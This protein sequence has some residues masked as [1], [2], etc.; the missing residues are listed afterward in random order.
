MILERAWCMPRHKTFEI[1]PVKKL[2]D[3]ELNSDFV[4]PF[5]YPYQRDALEYLKSFDDE[6][7]QNLAFDPPY[8]QRQLREMYDNIGQS[9]DMNNGYWAQCKDEIARITK[10]CGKV[11]SFGWNSSGIGKTRGFEITRILLVSHG[12]MP[13]DTICTVEKKTQTE[14]TKE[15]DA[16]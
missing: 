16:S 3:E 1:K 14:S 2:L 10:P 7:V 4:D 8:S 15:A 13:N 6:S 12:S 9:V 11:V 5:P